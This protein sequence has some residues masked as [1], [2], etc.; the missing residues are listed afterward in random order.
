VD[1]PAAGAEPQ[2]AI[3]AVAAV[4]GADE[5][6]LADGRSLRL[7][8]VQVPAEGEAGMAPTAEILAGWIAGRTLI[9]EPVPPPLDRHG[10]L[11]AQ[12]RTAGGRRWLQGE[13]VGQGLA[14]VAPAPDVPASVL[15]DL[16][17]IERAARAARRGLWAA[18]RHGPLP[19]ERA[20]A[21][22]GDYVLV[23]GRVRS[24]APAQSFVYLNFGDDWRRDFTV[25]ATKARA[26]SFTREG[27]DLARLA[28]RNLLVRGWLFAA[29]GPMIELVHPAQI[30]VAE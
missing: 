29:N 15:A 7:A 27:L 25:R 11:R 8:G 17:A 4:L 16:L 9:L 5:I 6:G 23:T 2:A 28:G 26:R 13:L 10:R 12:A 24:V 3:V 14:L 21:G 22:M 20:T 30:E 1:G 18:G 19:A